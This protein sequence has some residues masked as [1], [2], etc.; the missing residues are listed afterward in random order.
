[1]SYSLIVL[2]I[3]ICKKSFIFNRKLKKE[4][5]LI[6]SYEYYLFII[7][8]RITQSTMQMGWHFGEPLQVSHFIREFREFL[9]KYHIVVNCSTYPVL[10]REIEHGCVSWMRVDWDLST[11][12]DGCV[13]FSATGKQ[14]V[15]DKTKVCWLKISWLRVVLH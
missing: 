12:R 7:C 4:Y 9:I 8:T 10:D 5:R 1:M 6:V 2:W 3:L 14:S 11:R 15:S 13:S